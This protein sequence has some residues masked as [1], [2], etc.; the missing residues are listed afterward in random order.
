MLYVLDTHVLV[1]YFTG[2]ARLSPEERNLIDEVR[3]QGGRL[4]VPTIVLAEALNIAVKGRV[5]FDFQRLYQL[6]R[7]ESE[8]EIVEFGIEVFDE[9]L[10]VSAVPEIHDRIIVATARFFGADL[11]TKDGVIRSSGEVGVA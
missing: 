6:V 11:L 8:F 3:R 2:N 10:R 5:V 1:W 7:D 9:T 4:L